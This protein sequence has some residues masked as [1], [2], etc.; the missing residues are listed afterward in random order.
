MVLGFIVL[1][2]E[3]LRAIEFGYRYNFIDGV[4]KKNFKLLCYQSKSRNEINF[5]MK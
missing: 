2:Y 3:F 4:Q 1:R 5:K